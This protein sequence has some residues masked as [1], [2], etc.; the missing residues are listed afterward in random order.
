MQQLRSTRTACTFFLLICLSVIPAFSAEPL[1]RFVVG[2]GGHNRVDTPVCADLTGHPVGFPGESYRLVEVTGGR[3][4][5]VPVQFEA[6]SPPKLW[7]ILSGKTTAGSERVFELYADGGT[8]EDAVAVKK[9]EK[10]L[11]IQQGGTK[12]LSYNHAVIP[13]P[14]LE[15]MGER[16]KNNRDLYYR[17]GFIHPLWSPD[18][19]VLTNIHPDDHYHH[20]GIWMPWTHTQFK[21]KRVDFW[22]LGA[23][24]GTVRFN[25]ILRTE[26]GPVFGGF[27]VEHDHV[28]LND[29]KDD[30]DDVIALKEVWDVRVYNT[31]GPGEGY[32]L[33]DFVSAQRC[34]ADSPLELEAYRYGGFGFRGA[35][36]WDEDTAAYLT[37]EGKNRKDGHA[38]TAR[39]CDTSGISDGQWKGVTFFS[40][41][42]NL[43]H[44]EPMRIW[45]AGQ[46]FFN[47]VPI[48][49]KALMME[50]GE[51]FQFHYRQF[52]HEGKVDAA[53]S[54]ELWSDYAHPVNVAVDTVKPGDA[55]QLFDGRGESREDIFEHWTAGGDKKIGWKVE[56]GA[57]TIVPG[58]GGSIMTK[59][60]YRDFKLHVE[61]KTPQMPPNV[62][63]QGR[64]NSGV[65]L[66]RRYEVQI[67][68]SYGQEPKYNECAS[69]Y[70]QRAPDKNVCSM[71]G[72]WQSYDIVFHAAQFNVDGEKVKK[73][74]NARI[75]VWHNGVKVHDDVELTDKTGAGRQEGP[76][77]GPIL[78]QD[79]G[80]PV[81]FRNIWIEEL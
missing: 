37:S 21:G 4:E 40:N 23:G 14:P 52:V 18:G 78:L 54:E 30:S 60:T 55:V 49:K 75:T 35:A 79:H 10:V 26:S 32:W 59:E 63:G 16:Y 13:P 48:Q 15:K 70:R 31:G 25:R 41:P 72:R 39:W 19:S 80:N 2:A 81:S 6:G 58:G 69:L 20:L 1:A 46:V 61:F 42:N 51:D 64:G 28:V 43:R 38:T 47:W 27:Q 77:A 7:W 36:E 45:P 66:Q 9:T 22:N 57:M 62:K 29:V 74:K 33:W 34:V 67:L 12:V 76:E 5:N 53:K 50:P 17:S 11:L 71:P 3:R 8:K 65:Y 68:D 73:A 44:P 56:D 24:Q